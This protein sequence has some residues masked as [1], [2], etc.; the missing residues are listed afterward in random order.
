MFGF[1]KRKKTLGIFDLVL[2]VTDIPD[3]LSNAQDFEI[4]KILYESQKA[5]GSSLSRDEAL[6]IVREKR[7]PDRAQSIVDA[8]NMYGSLACWYPLLEHLAKNRLASGDI[9]AIH[10]HLLA[11]ENHAGSF[12]TL[13]VFIGDIVPPDAAFVP[14]LVDDLCRKAGN[15]SPLARAV[16]LHVGLFAIH[17]FRD[18]NKRT[19]RMLM[20]AV[21]ALHEHGPVMID[22]GNYDRYWEQY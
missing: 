13:P 4:W 14:S 5:E 22:A 10:A 20:N 16:F 3:E 9:L 8:Y 6:A 19:S 7:A 17:P 18:G 15:L 21:L 12:R 1:L 11:G 2:P